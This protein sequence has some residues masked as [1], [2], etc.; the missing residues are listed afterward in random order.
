MIRKRQ[1]LSEQQHDDSN[2]FPSGFNKNSV[3]RYG[4][5]TTLKKKNDKNNT[6]D[7]N[8]GNTKA[9]LVPSIQISPFSG[10]NNMDGNSDNNNMS[11][12]VEISHI[13]GE[14]N[15]KISI[16]SPAAAKFDLSDLTGW[17]EV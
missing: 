7:S 5:R 15:A 16:N 9:I 2:Y 4:N 10:M 6:M 8:D 14:M 13:E 12:V 11:P 1:I 17:E 3:K